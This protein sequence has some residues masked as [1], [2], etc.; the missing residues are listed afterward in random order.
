M[1]LAGSAKDIGFSALFEQQTQMKNRYPL[2]PPQKTNSQRPQ[3]NHPQNPTTK[4]H[5]ETT[6]K[7]TRR[8]ALRLGIREITLRYLTISFFT[9]GALPSEVMRTK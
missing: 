4:T 8:G 1:T 2:P 5:A 7:G 6:A 9:I 3:K